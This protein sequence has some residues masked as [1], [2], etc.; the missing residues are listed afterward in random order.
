MKAKDYIYKHYGVHKTSDLPESFDFDNVV[1]MM[2]HYARIKCKEQR[3]ICE[4][5]FFDEVDMQNE[6]WANI[7]AMSIRNAPEPEIQ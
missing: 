5:Y 7:T 3:E 6:R 2:K 1:D 4:E